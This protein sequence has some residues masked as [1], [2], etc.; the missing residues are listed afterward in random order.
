MAK[1]KIATNFTKLDPLQKKLAA[2]QKQLA[3]ANDDWEKAIEAAD[4]FH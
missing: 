2:V 3:T 1:P 4:E